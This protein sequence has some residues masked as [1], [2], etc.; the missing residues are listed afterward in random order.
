ME[1]RTIS[2]YTNN[3]VRLI[4]AGDERNPTQIFVCP[5]WRH[6]R[7]VEEEVCD[8]QEPTCECDQFAYIDK[9]Y[10]PMGTNTVTKADEAKIKRMLRAALK[11]CK[12]VTVTLTIEA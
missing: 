10:R 6:K 1:K 3:L 9:K 2:G 11:K 8:A 12:P 5:S 4:R 7:C